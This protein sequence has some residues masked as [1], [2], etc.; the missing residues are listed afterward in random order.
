MARGGP[1]WDD[2][3]CAVC[4]SDKARWEDLREKKLAILSKPRYRTDVEADLKRETKF[5][6]EATKKGLL[7]PFMLL[8]AM[9]PYFRNQAA[10]FLGWSLITEGMSLC[11]SPSYSNSNGKSP[12]ESHSMLSLHY[13]RSQHLDM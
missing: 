6:T 9:P 7:R 11:R 2:S 8:V 13:T 10:C 1:N 4:S 3:V 5:K 12:T